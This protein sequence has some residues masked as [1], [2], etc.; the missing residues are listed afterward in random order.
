MKVLDVISLGLELKVCNSVL[1]VL[2]ENYFLYIAISLQ[3]GLVL[4]LPWSK[5]RNEEYECKPR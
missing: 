1:H 4:R 2:L 5:S 3:P